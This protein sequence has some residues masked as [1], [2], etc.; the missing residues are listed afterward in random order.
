MPLALAIASAWLAART[1]EESGDAVF[2]STATGDV[3]VGAEVRDRNV[4]TAN[5]RIA[6]TPIDTAAIV[7]RVCNEVPE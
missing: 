7:N 5:A 1:A 3:V 6:A 2:A 4:M